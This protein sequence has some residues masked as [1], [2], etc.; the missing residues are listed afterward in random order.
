MQQKHFARKTF[1]W[2]LSSKHNSERMANSVLSIAKSEVMAHLEAKSE[3]KPKIP[4]NE[5][6][7]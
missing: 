4:P 7:N 6:E 3:N 1:K 5:G 2:Q